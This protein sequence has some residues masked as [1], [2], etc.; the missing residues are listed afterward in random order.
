MNYRLLPILFAGALPLL[1][2]DAPSPT[3]HELQAQVLLHTGPNDIVVNQHLIGRMLEE[4]ALGQHVRD[5]L[6]DG[7]EQVTESSAL[8][9]GEH[10][11]GTYQF[12]IYLT[13]AFVGEWTDATQDRCIDAAIDHLR[14]RLEDVLVAAPH[15]ECDERRERLERRHATQQKRSLDLRMQLER[16]ANDLERA[17]RNRRQIEEQ[18]LEAR[19]A[20]A[21][22]SNARK[23]LAKMRDENTALRDKLR[24]EIADSRDRRD[25]LNN[26]RIGLEA[27]FQ[28]EKP[29]ARDELRARMRKVAGQ[30]AEV[31]RG[32]DRWQELLGNIETMLLKVLQ[33]QPELELQW[34][35]ARARLESLRE[36][37][38]E[39]E[40]RL[41]QALEH[42]R[43]RAARTVERQQLDIDLEVT[44]RELAEVRARIGSMQPLRMQV[45]RPQAR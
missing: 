11:A 22:E 25:E 9:R 38:R 12:D 5:R 21:T 32:I 26:L 33:Q 39:A 42:E 10:R 19:L 23:H 35:R 18:L 41:G 37:Q 7:F 40:D 30:I 20:E 34:S 15:R 3:A 31:D 6:G 44:R 36:A 24:D 17:R 29:E 28:T 8:M 1:A 4:K 16:T 45:L 13:V 14:R 2:Q 43:E 27:R